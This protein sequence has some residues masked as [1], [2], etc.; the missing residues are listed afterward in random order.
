MKATAVLLAGAAA[1]LPVLG[2]QWP[3]AAAEAA[4][5]HAAPV[6]F[7]PPATPM[8]LSRTVIRE[9]SGGQQLVVTRRFRVQFVPSVSGYTLT[10][11]PLDVRIEVPPMLAKLAELER[12]RT[13]PGPFPLTVDARGMIQTADSTSAIPA[14]RDSIRQAGTAMIGT[15]PILPDQRRDAA[16]L[17]GQLAS[18]QRI[19]PWPADLFVAAN[20]ERRQHRSI[21]L[22][23]GSQG[24]V[25]VIL[26]VDQLLPCGMP[27]SFERIITTQLAGTQRISRERWTMA[28]LPD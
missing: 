20:G 22:A 7:S 5:T 26:K 13:D 2:A 15:A 19:S 8:V 25:E 10:G 27:A 28:M 4:P 12:Q 17:L 21:A 23:D 24:E 9:L 14:I 16:Q 1:V 6:R 18:N 11:A 3:G